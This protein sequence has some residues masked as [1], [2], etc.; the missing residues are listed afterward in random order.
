MN[1]TRLN[2]DFSLKF[3]NIEKFPSTHIVRNTHVTLNHSILFLRPCSDYPIEE[4]D[5]SILNGIE[6]FIHTSNSI[7]SQKFKIIDG[8]FFP[9][10]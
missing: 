7:I 3:N 6:N 2:L 1:K 4:R 8:Y 10:N 9:R 5:F